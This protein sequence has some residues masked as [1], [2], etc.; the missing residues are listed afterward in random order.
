[1]N[2]RPSIIHALGPFEQ[3]FKAMPQS[4]SKMLIE[5]RFPV[6]L[7]QQVGSLEDAYRRE[8]SANW[9]PVSDIPWDLLRVDRLEQRD[10]DAAR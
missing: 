9:N 7:G 2:C 1:M 4:H 3:L 6:R 10:R 8:K 5:R